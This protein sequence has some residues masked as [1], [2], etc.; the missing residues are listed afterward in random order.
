[1]NIRKASS[2]PAFLTAVDPKLRELVGR[3]TLRFA[4]DDTVRRIDM[5][6]WGS[7]NQLKDVE[8]EMYALFCLSE[9]L[10]RL[11]ASFVI[12]WVVVVVVVLELDLPLGCY[13][14][15]DVMST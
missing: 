4:K 8:N 15:S 12:W 14:S 11:K 2:F 6:M 1:M 3:S 9:A 7:K 13:R 5:T 10:R